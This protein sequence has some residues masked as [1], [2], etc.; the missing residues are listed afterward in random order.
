MYLD[1]C[2]VDTVLLK[3]ADEIFEV[4]FSWEVVTTVR[5]YSLKKCKKCRQLLF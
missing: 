2:E 1:M 3:V 4:L 5:P